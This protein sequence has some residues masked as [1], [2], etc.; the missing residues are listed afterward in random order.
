MTDRD[1]IWRNV[2]AVENK[3]NR[4]LAVRMIKKSSLC[5]HSDCVVSNKGHFLCECLEKV[6]HNMIDRNG[7]EDA[8][9]NKS[10]Y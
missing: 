2:N 10:I 4:L 5:E 8:T 9:E 7:T 1:I 6:I 3:K